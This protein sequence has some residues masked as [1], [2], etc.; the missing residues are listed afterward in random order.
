MKEVIVLP[1]SPEL[2]QDQKTL[3]DYIERMT[4]D[5]VEEA[6]DERT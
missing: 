1:V 5:P 2:M 4:A 6:D 3:R